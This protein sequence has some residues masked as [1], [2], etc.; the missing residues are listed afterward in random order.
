M[1]LTMNKAKMIALELERRLRHCAIYEVTRGN[2]RTDC[3]ADDEVRLRISE[4]KRMIMLK[5]MT[6]DELESWIFTK[7]SNPDYKEWIEENPLIF[8]DECI[9]ER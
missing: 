3:I 6:I 7:Y 4:F 5:E 9:D 1:A 8:K 2:L